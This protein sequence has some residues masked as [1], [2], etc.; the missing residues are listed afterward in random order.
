MK[1]LYTPTHFTREELCSPDWITYAKHQGYDPLMF[2]DDRILRQADLLREKFGPITI[3]DYS[4]GGRITQRGL[5]DW[6][7][8]KSRSLH[9]LGRAL[10][11][12]FHDVTAEQVRI[13]MQNYPQ[14]DW[15]RYVHRVE[16]DVSWLHIDTANVD[17]IYFFGG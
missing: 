12:I 9:K 5:R 10:D 17:P 3:N 14:E 7:Y 8:D 11:L 16:K 2:F 13:E 1:T 4:F 6:D 15:F